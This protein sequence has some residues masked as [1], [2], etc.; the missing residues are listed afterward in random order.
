MLY[1]VKESVIN[2]CGE[3]CWELAGEIE[4]P[5]ENPTQFHYAHRK[6]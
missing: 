6:V 5:G 4:V 1:N 3:V 2:E